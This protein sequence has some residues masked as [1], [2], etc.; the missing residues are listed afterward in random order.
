MK[1]NAATAAL[2]A[3]VLTFSIS[4]CVFLPS[5]AAPRDD[6]DPPPSDPV[7][8]DPAESFIDDPFDDG[9]EDPSESDD[10]EASDPSD[11]GT[12]LPEGWPEGIPVPPGTPDPSY[13]TADLYAVPLEREAYDAYVEEIRSL[14]DAVERTDT[15][16]GFGGAAFDIG[17]IGMTLTYNQAGGP[18]DSILFV[19]FQR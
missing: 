1:K 8:S 14:P 17:D 15:P 13:N 10:P 2:L 12:S 6:I 7:E 18:G 11:P 5:L 19:T 4:G 9:D 3:G 16:D